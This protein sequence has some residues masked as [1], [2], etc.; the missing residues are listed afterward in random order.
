LKVGAD[1]NY[2]VCLDIAM[3]EDLKLEG[4]ARELIRQINS[5]RKE[6]GLSIGDMVEVVYETKSKELK[7]T[8]AKFG[9]EIKAAT[10]T[11]KLSEGSGKVELDVNGGKITIGINK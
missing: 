2:K 8:L 11:K 7:E 5:Q 6:M 10:L 3:T 4:N 9:E 1:E